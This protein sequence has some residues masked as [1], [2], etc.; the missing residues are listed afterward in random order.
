MDY[1]NNI[2][3]RGGNGLNLMDYSDRVMPLWGLYK[4]TQ[5]IFIIAWVLLILSVY[6]NIKTIED[7]VRPL[8]QPL[9]VITVI[10][11]SYFFIRLRC[12]QCGR[13]YGKFLYFR[14]N[15]LYCGAIL[16]K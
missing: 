16:R 12:P 3:E 15:C 10:W 9:A 2:S 6:L 13:Y 8:R 5:I 14:K 4:K 7:F 11:F 1:G